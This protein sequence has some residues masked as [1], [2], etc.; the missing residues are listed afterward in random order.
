MVIKEARDSPKFEKLNFSSKPYG[1][2]HKQESMV[3]QLSGKIKKQKVIPK[4]KYLK[5]KTGNQVLQPHK[6]SY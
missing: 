6:D 2:V 3:V 5:V 4:S 1:S